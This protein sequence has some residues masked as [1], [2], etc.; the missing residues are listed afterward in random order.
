MDGTLY[1]TFKAL[2]G[3]RSCLQSGGTVR[4]DFEY[5]KKFGGGHGGRHLAT[6]KAEGR[7]DPDKD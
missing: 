1:V 3:Y 4:S 6:I 2:P 5:W 7:F